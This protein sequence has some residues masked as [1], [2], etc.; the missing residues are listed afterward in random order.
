M[1]QSTRLI[2]R[3]KTALAA[4]LAL[5]GWAVHVAAL[6][7]WLADPPLVHALRDKVSGTRPAVAGHTPA[8]D[9]ARSFGAWEPWNFP[10]VAPGR[11]LVGEREFASLAEAVAALAPGDTLRLGP[12]IYTS[13]LVIRQDDISLVGSGRVVFEGGVAEGKAAMV[14]KGQRFR[15]VNIECRGIQ[16]SDRNG[17][18]IRLEGADLTVEHVYFHASEQ[19]IL[20]G[21]QPGRVLIR[22]SRFESLGREGHAHGVYIGGGELHIED[23]LFLAAQDEGH[24]IK[25]RA[26]ITEIV[27][28]VVA[29]L[30]ARDSRLLDIA[31]GGV[32]SIRDSVLEKGPASA[33]GDAIGYGLEGLAYAGNAIE[34]VHNLIVLERDGPS[35]VL[36]AAAGGP[37]P[38]FRDNTVVAGENPGLDGLNLW[39]GSRR[40]AGL[41]GYPALP[42]NRGFGPR[43]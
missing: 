38:L 39:F 41:D 4:Y 37:V 40:V 9:I 11:I 15:I 16:V 2:A 22:D 20:T 8:D 10:A 43:P 6:G 36:H 27:R 29:S 33:N 14:V 32:L 18:C 28:T 26:R 25:S 12:G 35:Y 5:V 23:S 13:P 30:A 3:L 7:I 21:A 34:L 24:E 42:L 17:A 19:G 1:W 31:N